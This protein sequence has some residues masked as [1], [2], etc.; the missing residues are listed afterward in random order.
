MTAVARNR[1]D[2]E[3]ITA[4]AFAAAFKNRDRFRGEASPRREA[5]GAAV[6]YPTELQNVSDAAARKA[7]ATQTLIGRRIKLPIP[8]PKA[9]IR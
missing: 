2:A 8:T 6:P 1:E 3:D 4:T 5:G 7:I 9:K